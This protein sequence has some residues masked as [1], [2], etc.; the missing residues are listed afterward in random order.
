[1]SKRC[2]FAPTTNRKILS[3]EGCRGGVQ[4][5][6][7]SP[8]SSSPRRWAGHMPSRTVTVTIT[9]LVFAEGLPGPAAGALTH[10]P[11]DSSY[12]SSSFPANLLFSWTGANFSLSDSVVPKT[13]PGFWY[14]LVGGEY[15]GMLLYLMLFNVV[16]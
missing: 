10:S 11:F 3:G 1:M 8:V 5:A 7:Q 2:G 6:M 14:Q 13:A 9:Q 15:R 12:R 16:F 4:P